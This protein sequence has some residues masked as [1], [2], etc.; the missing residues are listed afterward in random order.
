MAKFGWFQGDSQKALR[1]FEGD[2]LEF[3]G[4]SVLVVTMMR[5][6]SNQNRAIAV[7]R[8]AAGQTVEIIK[9]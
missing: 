6:G 4:D 2:W 5:D 7:I 1:E 9:G 3:N 8:L